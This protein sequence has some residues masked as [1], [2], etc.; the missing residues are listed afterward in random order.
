[1]SCKIRYLLNTLLAIDN[2]IDA[3]LIF[4][5]G[6]WGFVGAGVSGSYVG[7]G[8]R[9]SGSFVLR[10]LVGWS[11]VGWSGVS[12]S[13]VGWG[14]VSWSRVSGSFVLGF[15]VFGVFCFAFVFHVSGV[16]IGVS[17]V[18]DDLD[19]AVGENDAVRSSDYVVVGFFIVLEV[20]VRFLILDIVSEAVGLRGL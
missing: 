10:L 20:I 4:G 15:F 11:S 17:L 12:W 19:A 2:A 5:V 1:M 18:G 7:W 14:G 9:V 8:G 3:N 13:S 6:N 16:S